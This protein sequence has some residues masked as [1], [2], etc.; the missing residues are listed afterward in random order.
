MMWVLQRYTA[1][2]PGLEPGNRSAYPATVAITF[3]SAQRIEDIAFRS[4]QLACIPFVDRPMMI[5][6]REV[7][8][9]MANGYLRSLIGQGIMLDAKAYYDPD[10]TRLNKL[11]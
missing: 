10:Q 5:A 4:I 3:H 11:L 9:E 7:I 2:E 8:L 1:K 6:L